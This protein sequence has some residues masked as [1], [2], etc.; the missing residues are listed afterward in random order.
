MPR[1]KVNLNDVQVQKPVPA[2]TYAIRVAS[3]KHQDAKETATQF[4]VFEYEIIENS[5]YKG[6]TLRDQATIFI[7][8]TKDPDGKKTQNSLGFLKEKLEALKFGWDPDGFDPEDIVG[9]TA[10]AVV[11]VGDYQGRAVNNV[12][13]LVAL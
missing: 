2:G 9:C 5:E 7:D 4:L 13:R 1:I 11:T 10:A 6:R 3:C 12:S 8:P